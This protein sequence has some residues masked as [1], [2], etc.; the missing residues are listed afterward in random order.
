MV[1]ITKP[2]KPFTF[3]GKGSIRKSTVIK[4]YE[5]EIEALYKA[6]EEAATLADIKPPTEWTVENVPAFIRDVVTTVMENKIGN[7]DDIFQNGGDSLQA[8]FMRNSII[9][10]L[11]QTNARNIKGEIIDTSTIS[12]GFVYQSPTINLLSQAVYGLIDPSTVETSNL[13]TR[14][15]D[16]LQ[17][18]IDE[19]SLDLPIHEP[20][21][22]EP[23]VYS[24]VIVVT[25]TTGAMGTA[26]LAQL[27]RMPTVAKIYA[28]N[29]GSKDG[30]DLYE[31][32][33][34]SLIERGYDPQV[35]LE[36]GTVELYEID[37][38][39]GDFGLEGYV[40]ELI[41]RTA[42][43]IIHTGESHLNA[44]RS[45]LS[46]LLAF[47]FPAW[48][49]DFN[50]SVASFEPLFKGLRNL[51]DL[52]LSSS[53]PTP[54]KILFAS[55]VSVLGTLN[56]D[57]PAVEAHIDDP[58]TVLNT[59]GYGESKWVAEQILARV[60]EKTPLKP[61]IVRI[62]QLSGGQNGSWNT[63]EWIPAV[64]KSGEV[65]RA[66]PASGDVSSF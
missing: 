12:A 16:E 65:V 3:T 10:A 28:L 38:G 11:R 29:R 55:S 44:F 13:K 26:I 66:L 61:V 33:E 4:D 50:L 46:V 59:S 51:I 39:A 9:S 49:V 17:K 21:D 36:S 54:P 35:V 2:E 27:A 45:S 34:E 15:I 60:A 37:P 41:R 23:S 7:N 20:T 58:T 53:L 56:S 47:S 32:Q 22:P 63:S 57:E 1:I 25:G 30:K 14:K 5:E 62:G 19:Y 8:T 6:V 43:T 52:S 31:R 48:R 24:E 64:I 40:Y 18:F 42:T